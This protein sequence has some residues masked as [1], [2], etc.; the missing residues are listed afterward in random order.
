VCRCRRSI[1]SS[2]HLGGLKFPIIR[3][4][5]CVAP[6]K[7]HVSLKLELKLTVGSGF[8]SFAPNL[9]NVERPL[10]GAVCDSYVIP[11]YYVDVTSYN[12]DGSIAT[13]GVRMGSGSTAG[14]L[15]ATGFD[16]M[17]GVEASTGAS[18]AVPTATSNSGFDGTTT[19]APTSTRTSGSDDVAGVSG[20]TGT[21]T[22][23]STSTPTSTSTSVSVG[24]AARLGWF[25]Y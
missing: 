9:S 1:L 20:S 8:G 10:S 5:S 16:G 7:N 24:H 3:H 25:A 23:V 6:S 22:S 15:L 19:S 12:D 13:M 11:K 2:V 14:M 21:T 4:T 18:T 17:S